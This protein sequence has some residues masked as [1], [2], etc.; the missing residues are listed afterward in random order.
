MGL[1][2]LFK[3]NKTTKPV[4]QNASQEIDYYDIVLYSGMKVEVTDDNGDTFPASFIVDLTN[5][6]FFEPDT[7]LFFEPQYDNDGVPKPFEVRA[8]GYHTGFKKAIHLEGNVLLDEEH[9]WR[10]G[11]MDV[12]EVINDRAYHRIP[13]DVEGE[14][15]VP[16]FGRIACNINDISVGGVRMSCDA[17]LT[18]GESVNI[19]VSLIEDEPKVTLKCVVMRPHLEDGKYVYGCRFDEIGDAA[20]SEISRAIFR[21]QVSNRK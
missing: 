19:M 17:E 12:V 6:M 3:K 9:K 14:V 7:E 1:M 4:V 11:Y 21:S 13:I 5:S 20:E 15:T 8:R 16:L 18:K 10:I 2:S